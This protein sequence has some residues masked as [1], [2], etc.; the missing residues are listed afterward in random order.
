[1]NKLRRCYAVLVLTLSLSAASREI[2][3]SP[4]V[5]VSPG[6]IAADTLPS[7]FNA[8]D[9]IQRIR[10]LMERFGIMIWRMMWGYIL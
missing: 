1:M 8:L 5:A 3:N 7:S 6:V 4:A 2:Y 9:R 10:I